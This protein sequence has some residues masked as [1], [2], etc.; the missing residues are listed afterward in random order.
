MDEFNYF[1]YVNDKNVVEQVITCDDPDKLRSIQQYQ[2]LGLS[3]GRWIQATEKTRR[4]SKGNNYDPVKNIFYPEQRFASW[5][6]NEETMW[7]EPPYPKP[8]ITEKDGRL[9]STWNWDEDTLQWIPQT[10]VNCG[11]NDE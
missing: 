9:I 2:A 7:W 6:L 3:P 4:P 8:P 5:H 11:P 10:C 1:A